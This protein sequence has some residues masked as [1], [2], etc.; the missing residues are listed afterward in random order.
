LALLFGVASVPIQAAT[1]SYAG[2]TYDTISNNTTCTIG[3]CP[4]TYTTAMRVTGSF[5]TA[6]PLAANLSN[7]DVS[8]LVTSYSYNDGIN[9]IASGDPNARINDFHVSTDGSGAIVSPFSIVVNRWTTGT[10]PHSA[11]DRFNQISFNNANSSA[12]NDGFCVI[13]TTTDSADDC[14]GIAGD[15]NTSG[16]SSTTPQAPVFLSAVSRRL[17]GAAGTFDLPLLTVVPPA[18]NHNPTT[19]PRQGPNQTIVFTF[20]KP[21]NA[22]TVSISEG[23]ATAATPTFSGNDVVVGLTGVTDRQYVTVDLTNVASTDGGTGGT[24]S[25][26]AGFLVGDVNQT[27]VVSV[28]DLGL[29]NA[30]LAQTVT[31][32]NFLKDVNGSGTVT[33]ADKGITNANLT[34]ALPTP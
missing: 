20:D 16:A 30:Q 11:G 15:S 2:T 26:R 1:Y 17:H 22:A 19:E 6:G 25:V 7:V 31:A 34:Q 23:V 4:A 29:V 18:V 32:S 13:V 27:R 14:S 9:T 5:T 12:V 24:A 3:N 21:L 8:S 28:A 10:S 33:L